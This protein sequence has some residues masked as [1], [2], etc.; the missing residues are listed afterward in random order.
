MVARMAK[1]KTCGRL[2]DSKAKVCKGCGRPDPG[3]ASTTAAVIFF[4]ALALFGAFSEKSDPNST[5]PTE[6]VSEATSGF[7][8]EFTDS[9][10]PDPNT[11]DSLSET[12]TTQDSDSSVLTNDV[13][14]NFDPA[15]F[16]Y[17]A[18]LVDSNER[19]VIQS[20]PAMT[21][22]NIEVLAA[23]DIVHA[24]SK[25]GKWIAVSIHDGRI[26]YVRKRQLEFY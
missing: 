9:P 22:K 23:G 21:S 1:C 11:T 19:V 24:S 18:R 10:N 5:N 16:P 8:P 17:R 12:E 4:L 25:D 2:V 7:Q 14:K 3:Q 6:Q 26:G 20:K 15:S 13:T